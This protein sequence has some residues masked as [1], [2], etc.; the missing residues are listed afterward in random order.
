MAQ[1][2]LTTP[3][4]RVSMPGPAKPYVAGQPSP[5]PGGRPKKTEAEYEAER[6]AKERSPRAVSRL[7]EILESEDEKAAIMAANSILDRA[8]GKP[9]Q[10]ITAE[11]D[12]KG[13]AATPELVRHE[14]ARLLTQL[15][16]KRVPIEAEAV[17][18]QALPSP[19]VPQ[20]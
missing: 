6:I 20:E 8:L 2:A 19:K 18:V 11:V 3:R 13:D 5:N 15:A 12:M 17:A 1:G 16:P 7:C 14:L 4:A 9:T 10:A